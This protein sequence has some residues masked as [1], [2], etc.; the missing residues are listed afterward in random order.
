MH[1]HNQCSY[2]KPTKQITNA[3]TPVSSTR[4]ITQQHMD[5][6]TGLT[7]PADQLVAVNSQQTVCMF[8]PQ[9]ILQGCILHVMA[10]PALPTCF[11]PKPCMQR[12]LAV[13]KHIL[14][15][16]KPAACTTCSSYPNQRAFCRSCSASFFAISAKPAAVSAKS[17]VDSCRRD[18]SQ[19]R[20]WEN[21]NK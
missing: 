1:V 14:S 2:L 19:R 17:P 4:Q 13:L 16:Q 18:I 15:T 20:R 8:T 21:Q 7:P 3:A 5:S 10:A 12:V 11:K 9:A 6:C